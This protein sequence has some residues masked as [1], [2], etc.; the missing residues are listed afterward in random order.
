V[1]A[2]A[3]IEEVVGPHLAVD[4]VTRRQRDAVQPIQRA[5]ELDAEG[6]GHGRA[7]RRAGRS[8]PGPDRT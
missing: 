8:A 7:E 6:H 5:T 4:R 2:E 1:S 3:D